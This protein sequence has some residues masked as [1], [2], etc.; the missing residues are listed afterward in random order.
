MNI[1]KEPKAKLTLSVKKSAIEQAK[2]YAELEGSSLSNIVEEFLVE[3]AKTS[4]KDDVEFKKSL[5]F[6]LM[7]CAKGP[8]SN[9][10]DK[11]L[12]DMWAKEKYGL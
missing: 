4:K 5:P 7:G 9:M 2:E 6:L 10:S 12:K 3:Y 11:E 8:L 1:P